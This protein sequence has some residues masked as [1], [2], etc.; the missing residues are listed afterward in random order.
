MTLI[1]LAAYLSPLIRFRHTIDIF[2][3]R[4]AATIF[5]L[6]LYLVTMYIFGLYNLNRTF[7]SRDSALRAALAVVIAG[8]FAIFLFYSLPQWKYGWGIFLIQMILVWLFLFGWRSIFALVFPVSGDKEDVLVIGAGRSGMALLQVLESQS[9]P[10]MIVGFLDDDPIKV[11][12]S[13]PVLGPTSRLMEIASQ[14]G[15]RTAILAITHGIN[16]KLLEILMSCL[17]LGVQIV[18]MPALYEQLTGRV[19]IDYVGDNWYMAMPLQHPGT[20]P[21]NRLIKRISDI[22]LA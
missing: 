21:L 17:E 11:A 19:P 4:T 1:L 14:R 20:R 10:Y 9:A 8:F 2:H 12:A 22:I 15:V 18:L 7:W 5:T 3:L 16:S 6:L 13:P